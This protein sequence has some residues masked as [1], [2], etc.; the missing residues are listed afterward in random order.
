MNK[1]FFLLLNI[2]KLSDCLAPVLSP[3]NYYMVQSSDVREN[4]ATFRQK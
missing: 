2:I 1:F 4:E 3:T